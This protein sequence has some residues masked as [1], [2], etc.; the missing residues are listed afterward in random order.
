[1]THLDCTCI[2]NGQSIINKRL[3]CVVY[4]VITII[5]N[6]INTEM[7]TNPPSNAVRLTFLKLFTFLRNLEF[8]Y[9]QSFYF[10]SFHKKHT[11][12]II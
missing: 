6:V 3:F 2:V 9:L 10:P 7:V 1:M 5:V 8:F 11:Y 4:E 12:T